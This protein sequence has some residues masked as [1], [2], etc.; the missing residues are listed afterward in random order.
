MTSV[1]PL[2]SPLLSLSQRKRDRGRDKK[3]E[4]SLNYS[5]GG[6]GQG[7]SPQEAGRDRAV[8]AGVAAEARWQRTQRWQRRCLAAAGKRQE[9]Q[10][11]G[12]R[13]SFL[14]APASWGSTGV[15]HEVLS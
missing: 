2:L 1:S 3:Q 10:E 8:R 15:A 14:H 9:Q 5:Q 7:A 4:E 11:G 6:E 13:P 12:G